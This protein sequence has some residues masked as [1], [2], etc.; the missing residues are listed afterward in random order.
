M[1]NYILRAG[2]HQRGGRVINIKGGIKNMIFN[3]C[4]LDVKSRGNP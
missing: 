4:K 3:K 2:G 1:R